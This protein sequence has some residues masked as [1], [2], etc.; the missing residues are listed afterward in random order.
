MVLGKLKIGARLS[1]SL[2]LLV[3]FMV[4]LIGIGIWTTSHINRN[5]ERIVQVN[6][7]KAE[8]AYKIKDSINAIDK[9][10][11]TI[12]TVKDEMT[13][14]EEKIKIGKTRI[15]YKDAMEKLEKLEINT[16][17]QELIKNI[18]DAL[19]AARDSNTK[20][21]ELG[22]SDNATEAIAIFVSVTKLASQKL[23][24]LCDQLVSFQQERTE[25]RF[26]ESQK[27]YRNARNIL[28][29]IG[30]IVIG[31]A[32]FLA[33]TL[34]R[35][36]IKPLNN[37]VEI[38]NRLAKGELTTHIEVTGNDETS[39]LL[40]AIKNMTNGLRNIISEVK[41]AAAN[42]AS[43]SHQ[44]SASSEQMSRGAGQ[45]AE[46][47]SQVATASEEMSQTVFD[48]AKNT[49][50]IET[51]ATKTANLAKEG[52]D[53]VDNAV[54]EIEAIAK[55]TDDS[56]RLIY[57]LGGRSTQIGEIIS[58]INEIADQTNLLALNAAIEAA[59]AGEAGRGF[60]VVA[61]EVKKLAERTANSTSEIG[62]MI[63][64]I[65]EEV[66]QTVS[67][68]ESVT[69]QVGIGVELSAQAGNV[70]GNIVAGVDELN[71]M[72]HQIASATEEMAATSEEISKDIESI[73]SISRETSTSSDQIAYASQEMSRLA[74]NLE[75]DVSGFTV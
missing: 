17:G 49:S 44:L 52:R 60:A 72:V 31:I 70:L 32:I 27:A 45:Q 10:I 38:A 15:I 22:L 14:N 42:V 34:T 51:S 59:R 47:A 12:I 58:V 36:I 9:G 56:S 39:Q 74:I 25:F 40:E 48:I 65:Q 4:I 75:K 24:D 30:F 53:V 50:N 73:A 71:S 2:G 55:M 1:V 16:K 20:A 33:I 18:K 63:K 3:L 67:S 68:M 21:M 69:K 64:S 66:K 46:R 8:L 13:K 23:N 61:D 41:T 19:I 7:A 54:K 28:F 57:S 29:I 62:G 5:L 11:I 35:S 6:N 26:K 37:G 43:A